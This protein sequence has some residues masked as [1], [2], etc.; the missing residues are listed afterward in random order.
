L[1]IQYLLNCNTPYLHSHKF[2][3][4]HFQLKCSFKAMLFGKWQGSQHNPLT[5]RF[6]FWYIMELKIHL[7]TKQRDREREIE[8]E[9]EKKRQ[10]EKYDNCGG[11]SYFCRFLTL[12][13][14]LCE[15]NVG[16]RILSQNSMWFRAC[17]V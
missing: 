5:K 10:Y 11:K 6:F 14:S 16:P 8:R 2:V 15:L 12:A 3:Y 9:R 17:L 7:K 13:H 4:I 1:R